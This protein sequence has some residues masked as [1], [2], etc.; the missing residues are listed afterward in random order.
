MARKSA[1]QSPA[2]VWRSALRALV[3]LSCLTPLSA[4]RANPFD[5]GWTLNLDGSN[6]QFQSVKKSTVVETSSFANFGGSIDAT[7]RATVEVLLDS[8]DTTIDLRNVRMRFL[9]FETFQFPKAVITMDLDRGTLADLPDVRR[10]IVTLPYTIELHG[11]SKTLKT[12][13]AITMI[14]DDVISVA[15][16]TPILLSVAD[17]GLDGGLQKL[18]EA[19]N[20]SI[21]PSASVTFD[22][23]FQRD[24]SIAAAGGAS[25]A[26]QNIPP[27]S[28]ALETAGDFSV[29][30]CVGRFEILSRTDNIYF[31]VGSASLDPNSRLILETVVDIIRRCP[32]LVIEVSGHTDD[33]GDFESNQRLSE[34]RAESVKS[35][36]TERGIASFRVISVGLG[37]SRP[38]FPNDSGQ[39]KQRNRRIEFKVIGN[40]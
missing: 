37:E 35:Y 27:A 7:G 32:G 2:F 8:I 4:V 21:V 30:E 1:W 39:N 22:F 5:P 38:A 33:D 16:R 36:I 29:E 13:M 17:F 3:L 19:A 10:K 25:P 15:S 23:L 20:V 18:E 31:A 34:Q 24:G 12:D 11:V 40:G 26:G 9:F 6:L 14:D 28:V